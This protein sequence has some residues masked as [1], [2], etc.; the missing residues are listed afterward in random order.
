MSRDSA[1]WKESPVAEDIKLYNGY[2]FPHVGPKTARQT[3]VLAGTAIR[4][5]EGIDT[6]RKKCCRALVR[7]WSSK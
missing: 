6:S 3:P 5:R 2:D 7:R 4:E 1:S